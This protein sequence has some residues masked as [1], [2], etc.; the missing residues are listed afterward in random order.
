[1]I[2]KIIIMIKILMAQIITNKVTMCFCPHNYKVH[3]VM[4]LI[5]SSYIT[6][7]VIQ[8][9]ININI[10]FIIDIFNTVVRELRI[11]LSNW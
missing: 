9:T 1:M 5:G 3:N 11:T 7:P 2:Q 6:N 10:S 8:F 4:A